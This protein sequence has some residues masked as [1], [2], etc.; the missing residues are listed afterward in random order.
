MRIEGVINGKVKNTGGS[1]GRYWRRIKVV[2][3]VVYGKTGAGNLMVKVSR[4]LDR[5]NLEKSE[6]EVG[7]WKFGGFYL[8]NVGVGKSGEVKHGKDGEREI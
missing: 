7:S 3:R 6:A 1:M 5:G 4:G 2:K 8:Q